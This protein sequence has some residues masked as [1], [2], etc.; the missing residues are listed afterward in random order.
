MKLVSKKTKK[1]IAKSVRKA[2]KKHGPALA[3]AIVG[4]LASTVATLASTEA[5]RTRGKWN[6]KDVM[7]RATK[8][9]AETASG[10]P[11]RRPSRRGDRPDADGDAEESPA[12]RD[13]ERAPH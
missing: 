9:V 6:L 10:E 13:V 2:L 1:A 11:E 3:A 12:A 8:A 5:P 7:D 4:S